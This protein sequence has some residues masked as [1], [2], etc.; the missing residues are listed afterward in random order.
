MKKVLLFGLCCT[1]FLTGCGSKKLTCTKTETE[2]GLKM[3]TEVKFNFDSKGEAIKKGN[4]LGKAEVIEEYIKYIDEVKEI[5]EEGYK[6]I[7]DVASIEITTKDNTVTVKGK[8]DT[9]K[10]TED[11]KDELYYSDLYDFGN[12]D[13]VKSEYEE[14]GY[15]CK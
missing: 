5:L 6:D 3:S 12:Y 10:L 14:M 2:E 11:Q 4:F 1:L 13:E 9:S 15:T 8:Y 7:K